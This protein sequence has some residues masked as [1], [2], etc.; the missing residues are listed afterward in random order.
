MGTVCFSHHNDVHN[1]SFQSG[2]TGRSLLGKASGGMGD[3]QGNPWE[4]VLQGGG[5][6]EVLP[7]AA[8]QGDGGC[9]NNGDHGYKMALMEHSDW[10]EEEMNEKRLGFAPSPAFYEMEEDSFES[11][12]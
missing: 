3:I 12:V 8:E 10:T 6:H 1:L 4:G 5:P 11:A 2:P 9:H 7:V